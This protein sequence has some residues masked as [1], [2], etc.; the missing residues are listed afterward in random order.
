MGKWGL[1]AG[2]GDR[3][4]SQRDCYCL[5]F[6]LSLSF[7]LSV[8]LS[9]SHPLARFVSLRTDPPPPPFTCIARTIDGFDHQGLLLS[10]LHSILTSSTPIESRIRSAHSRRDP[11][12]NS[13]S[14]R[15]DP[16]PRADP[17]VRF[18]IP[19]PDPDPARKGDGVVVKTRP[20][21]RPYDLGWKGNWQAFWRGRNGGK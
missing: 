1:G 11:R 13:P 4:G 7:F 8:F 5:S 10:S 9:H 17:R 15:T 21:E 6:S 18:W 19:N 3:V 20:D 12:A 14:S 16:H 2:G